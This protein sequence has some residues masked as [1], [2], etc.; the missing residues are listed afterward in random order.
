MSGDEA[1]GEEGVGLPVSTHRVTA[2]ALVT[3]AA[4]LLFSIA[5]ARAPWPP[6]LFPKYLYAVQKMHTADLLGIAPSDQ[7]DRSGDYSPLYLRFTQILEPTGSQGLLFANCFLM[8][9]ASAAVALTVAQLAGLSWGLGAG[10][11]TASYP[12]LL[13]QTGVHEPEILLVGCLSVAMLLGVVARGSL[14]RRREGLAVTGWPAFS[15][16][17]AVAGAVI[18]FVF[19]LLKRRKEPAHN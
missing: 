9:L 6:G 8:A 5:V 15:G 3:I 7:A 14:E 4:S 1:T 2:L 11:L 17:L 10:L 16:W 18:W 19:S 12:P 13:T